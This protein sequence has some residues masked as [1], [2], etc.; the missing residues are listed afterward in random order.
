MSD[1]GGAAL[2]YRGDERGNGPVASTGE[3]DA[4]TTN[5]RSMTETG[6]A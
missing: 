3:G 1:E 4:G 2:T 6:E 5:G